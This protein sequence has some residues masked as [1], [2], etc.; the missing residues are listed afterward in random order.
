MQK[1]GARIS[2]LVF[3]GTQTAE[4]MENEVGDSAHPHLRV[5]FS[6]MY[7]LLV[8]TCSSTHVVDK[9]IG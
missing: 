1:C 6:G 8:C 2:N 4:R 9:P 3:L 5:E 7:H